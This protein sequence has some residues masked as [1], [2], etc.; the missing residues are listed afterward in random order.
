MATIS[1]GLLTSISQ[2]AECHFIWVAKSN[3]TGKVNVYFGEGPSPDQ[4]QFLSGIEGMKVWSIANDGQSAEVDFELK[5][6]GDSGWFQVAS[7]SNWVDIDCEYGVF[8]RGDK[9][10]FLHYCAKY[11][12]HQSG[13]STKASG[14][15]PLD[16]SFIAQDSQ[17]IFHI[18]FNKKAAS[19]SEF[20]VIDENGKSH[21]FKTDAQGQV[22]VPKKVSGRWQVRAKL[23]KPES[24][25]HDGK[26]YSE[27]RYYCTLIL[28]AANSS[29]EKT[30]VSINSTSE[31]PTKRLKC[32]T[33]FPVL[34]V[35]ITSFGGAVVTNDLYVFGGHCGKAH[36]YYQSGQNGHLYR[37]DV[38]NPS[39][40]ESVCESQG[41]QG[42][43]MVEHNGNLYRMGGFEARNSKGEK[44]DLHSVDEFAKF[45]FETKTWKQLQPM[46]IP[47]SSL[48]AVV[49][50]DI[51]F[52]VGGWTMKGQEETVWCENAI[53]IDLSA[54]EAKWETIE[55]PFKR[56]ALSV[57][58]QS[59]KLYAVGGMQQ[60]GGPTSGVK[61]YDLENK[62][63]SDGPSLPGAGSMEGFGSSC[64]NIGGH[65]IVS[66]YGGDVL[67]LN[68]A[69]EGWEK[70]HELET[71]R[72]F[73]RLL[74]V[75]N[76]KFM[77]VGGANMDVGKIFD[78]EVLS[79]N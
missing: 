38:K 36:E 6:K 65:L 69:E 53:S 48:D 27:K 41:R 21:D 66:T 11:A 39:K 78:V 15:L 61:V 7:E 44:Q 25:E 77:L 8:G 74:P 19:E 45:D 54:D 34:P 16:I 24:G 35:G 71:G 33:P 57:G 26:K 50:G 63:W 68:S 23:T 13:E 14:K 60:K 20:S 40:W 5:S 59:N 79:L 12:S 73:H 31:V 51:L 47:R 46:P 43:A 1:I 75:S 76:S 2:H 70:I 18:S 72:F 37:L 22:I 49:V 9:T 17:T 42:L 64:F 28:D 58:H 4:K 67:R 10:M 52:V 29:V 30:E 55:V 32:E 62:T 3:E 56:R